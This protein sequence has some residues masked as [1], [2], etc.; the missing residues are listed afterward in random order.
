MGEAD[1]DPAVFDSR[2]PKVAGGGRQ[3]IAAEADREIY[4]EAIDRGGEVRMLATLFAGLGR[5]A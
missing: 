3:R 5:D 1:C 2:L 4:P